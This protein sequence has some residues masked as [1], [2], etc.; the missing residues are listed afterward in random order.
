MTGYCGHSNEPSG[1]V[2]SVSFS[3]V[4]EL[5]ADPQEGSRYVELGTNF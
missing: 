4:S 3:S 5:L 2:I 1:S